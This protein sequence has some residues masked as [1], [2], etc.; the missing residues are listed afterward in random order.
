ME[1]GGSRGGVENEDLNQEA[2]YKEPITRK[3]VLFCFRVLGAAFS[4]SGA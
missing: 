2:K 3:Q 1:F 4:F